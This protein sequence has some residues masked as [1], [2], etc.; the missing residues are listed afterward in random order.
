MGKNRLIVESHTP[1]EYTEE[2]LSELYKCQQSA[3][4]F[5]NN[6]CYL[7][8]PTDGKVK[9]TLYDFQNRILDNVIDNR[10]CIVLAPRQCG[11][12]SVIA[13]IIL[14]YAMF[15]PYKCC[16]ILANKDSKSTSI[17]K[18][19]KNAYENL[20]EWMKVG[21][22]VYNEHTITFENGSKIF[23]SATSKDAI[24][25]E[26]VSFLYIDECALIPENLAQD[27]YKANYPTISKGEKL[28]V[29]STA[30]GVG[31]LF[32]SLWK[33]ALEKKNTYVPV[34]VDYWE[35][36]DYST[37]EWKEKMIADLGI[38]GFNSEYGNQFIGSQS[39][40]IR[41]EVLKEFSS[42]DPIYSEDLFDGTLKVYEEYDPQAVYI[43]SNDISLGCGNDY[44]TSQIFRAEWRFPNEDDHRE[45]KDKPDDLPEVIITNL[46]QCVVFRSNLISIPDFVKFC[47]IDLFPRWG[48]PYFILE[49]N[50]IGQSFADKM[51]EEYYYENTYYYIPPT[52][53]TKTSH[54]PG[55]R[56]D[57][58][59]KSKMVG[60]LKTFAEKGRLK[61]Y[62][63]DTITELLM[64]VEKKTAFKNSK[65]L[66]DAEGHDDLVI[67]AGWA[68]YLAGTVW[69]Q[70]VLSYE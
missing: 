10:Q 35:V 56:S 27:F 43:A 50:G 13:L 26:S 24:A 5:A 60:A 1:I 25:G 68:C 6:Y 55:I 52:G 15:Q 29:T 49:N 28:V 70:D 17:L 33:G 36:P 54:I 63:A 51:M 58:F 32:H 11:K 31:N 62:D 8:H 48:N 19:I 66:A 3:K 23:A 61:I 38:I 21:V 57:G 37:K 40:V 41:G 42:K 64:F 53:A 39:T 9:A 69:M 59:L 4:Y 34:R 65:F 18:D 2:M 46:V 14:H 12:T 16:A 30:R 22:D 45:Y 44:S 47:F 67:G 7:I 20:P